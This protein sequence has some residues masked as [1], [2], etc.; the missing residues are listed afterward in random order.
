MSH[1][2]G[3]SETCDYRV[4]LSLSCVQ[5]RP[6]ASDF[7][8]HSSVAMRCH[9]AASPFPGDGHRFVAGLLRAPADRW[10]RLKEDMSVPRNEE[11]LEGGKFKVVSA[12]PVRTVMSSGLA[13]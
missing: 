10:P 3:F 5:G 8:T 2:L 4:S 6:S 7:S 9:G 12:A 1:Y 11:F 13:M